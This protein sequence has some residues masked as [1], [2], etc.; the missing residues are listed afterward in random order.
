[1]SST[2]PKRRSGTAEMAEPAGVDERCAH[3]GRWRGQEI[4]AHR[5]ATSGG[6]S[7]DRRR[8]LPVGPFGSDSTSHTCRGYL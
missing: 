3:V 7:T 2:V 5:E 6:T 8:I 1:M 4:S